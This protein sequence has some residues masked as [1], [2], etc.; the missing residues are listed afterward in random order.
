[1]VCASASAGADTPRSAADAAVAET[2][3]SFSSEVC[4]AGSANQY[5]AA[6][7]SVYILCSVTVFPAVSVTSAQ[8]ESESNVYFSASAAFPSFAVSKNTRSPSSAVAPT[9]TVIV[10]PGFA[11]AVSAESDGLPPSWLN[12]GSMSDRNTTTAVNTDRSPTV[13]WRRRTCLCLVT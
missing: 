4:P 8:L 3:S 9:V 12:A 11:L 5:S 1:M 7:E 6:P 2:K 13:P 10:S